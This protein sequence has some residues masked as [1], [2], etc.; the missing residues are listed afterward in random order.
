M[1]NTGNVKQSKTF[2]SLR[3]K[4]F[5]SIFGV[6]FLICALEVVDQFFHLNDTI[7]YIG[8]FAVL[9]ASLLL[10]QIVSSKV[11]EPINKIRF[12]INELNLGH[13][14]QRCNIMSKDEIGSIAKDLDAFAANFDSVIIETSRRIALGDVSVTIDAHDEKDI[15]AK[16][17]NSTVE[18]VNS[19]VNET[20]SIIKAANLGDLSK[21]CNT[22]RYK[23]SWALLAQG[24]NNLLNMISKPIDEVRK[25]ADKL[26]LNDYTEKVEGKYQGIFKDLA[27]DVNNVR[28]RLLS[29]QDIMVNLSKGDTSRL[30]ELNKIQKL[31]ENDHMLPAAISMMDSIEKLIDE[32][33]YVTA[34][35]VNGNVISTR[36]KADKFEGGYKEIIKGFNFTLDAVAKPLSDMLNILGK[37]ALNDFTIKVSEDYKGD[38]LT[39]AQ[40]VNNVQS[41][42]LL[43]QDTAKRI[44]NGDVS[45]LEYYRS[46]GRRCDNDELLPA[47]TQMMESISELIKETTEIAKSASEGDLSIRGISD[48]F[49]GGYISIIHSINN[50][51]DAVEDPVNSVINVMESIAVGKLDDRISSEYK[52]KFDELADAVNNTA[53]KFEYLIDQISNV[54]TKVSKGD[55][56]IDKIDEFDGEFG[57]IS[58]AL[59]LIID[60]LNSLMS[61]I[62]ATSEQVA[63][64]S[65]QVSQGSQSLS[66]GAAEQA[67]A[68]EELTSSIT[69]IAAKTKNNAQSANKANELAV[70]VS[71]D[72]TSG[73]E[74]MDEMLK[75]MNDINESSNN[76]LK[77][78]KVIDNIA[79]QTN[80][81]ALNAAIE[82]A[83]AGQYG[84]GFA[85]VAEEVRNLASKSTDAADQT[86]ALI[87]NT[88]SKVTSGTKMANETA[89]TFTGIVEGIDNVAN[90]IAEIA[91]A[92]NEQ[93]TGITMV[94]KGLMQVSEVVQTNSATSEESAAAS[95]ELSGQASVLKQ[96][97]SHFTLRRVN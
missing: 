12:T 96:E 48:K 55:L 63:A 4:L 72:A 57:S 45:Q 88:V 79:F 94:D 95:E 69:Q 7:I 60:S 82:A 66:Q 31:S 14:H 15:V 51:L 58:T 53:S 2:F 20:N 24:I 85:V 59:N 43:A 3:K 32:I 11:V 65:I 8:L 37:I 28:E 1:V 26:S 49:K 17:L 97:V 52:G 40:T 56:N 44:A 77:I 76:I 80:I 73:S 71:K 29:I 64:G 25:V 10:A 38:Y 30:S 46:I 68:V 18:T 83:R 13:I 34:E 35:A 61:N 39:L 62:N 70:N 5:G 6:A 67:S 89:K 23:G 81:L 33:E 92:T 36:G 41:H 47:Y 91:E 84:K 90:L 9:M 93:S 74:K 50:L 21:R 87:E 78:I 19:I 75:S 86:T 54:M 22:D 42:L 16:A 27:D